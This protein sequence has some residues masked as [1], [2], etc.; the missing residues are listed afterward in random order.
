MKWICCRCGT[1][2]NSRYQCVECGVWNTSDYVCRECGAL[3][4]P[5]ERCKKCG[6]EFCEY[7]EVLSEDS[8]EDMNEHYDDLMM[9]VPPE[10]QIDQWF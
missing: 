8:M 6:H 9:G 4:D 5:D 10:E 3:N 7:C 2:N 1:A